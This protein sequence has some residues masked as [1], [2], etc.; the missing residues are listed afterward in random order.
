MSGRVPGNPGFVKAVGD[1][2]KK[3]RLGIVGRADC[4]RGNGC[5]PLAAV[6]IGDRGGSMDHWFSF[7]RTHVLRH[8]MIM[9]SFKGFDNLPK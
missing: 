2:E 8:T 9:T 3:G 4:V 5:R 7:V 1:G 6:V